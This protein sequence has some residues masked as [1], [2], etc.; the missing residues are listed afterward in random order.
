MRTDTSTN[1][2][3][4]NGRSNGT[5]H[6]GTSERGAAPSGANGRVN[7]AAPAP[8]RTPQAT[9]AGRTPQGTAA[10]TNHPDTA[11]PTGRGRHRRPRPRKA[12]LTAGGLALAAGV[13]SLVRLASPDSGNGSAGVTAAGPSPDAAVDSEHEQATNTSATAPAPLGRPSAFPTHGTTHTIPVPSSSNAAAQPYAPPPPSGKATTVPDAPDASTTPGSTSRPAPPQGPPTT[14][15]TP[16]PNPGTPTPQPD[17]PGLCLPVIDL[18]LGPLG[19][20]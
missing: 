1:I 6:D 4:R 9:T 17:D 2:R 5:G 8:G 11:A 13:L 7:G 3:T 20:R 12:L 15:P 19:Q 16:P 18:C 10:T 14:S